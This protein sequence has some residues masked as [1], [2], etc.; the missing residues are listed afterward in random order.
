MLSAL[1]IRQFRNVSK[2]ASVAGPNSDR[3]VNIKWSDGKTGEFPLIWLRDTSPDPSTYTI[4]PAMT[5]RNL[6]MMEFDVEQKAKKIWIDSDEDSLKIEWESGIKS[7]FSSEWLQIRNPSDEEARK[8]RRKV[9]LFPEET[10]GKEEIER[11]LK[12]FSHEDFMKNDR[13]VHDFLQAVCID[14]IAVLKGAPKGVKG[15]VEDIGNRIGMIK[16]THFGKFRFHWFFLIF[17]S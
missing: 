11:K 9:Y 16:R 8:R 15:A 3:I 6:T 13:V 1:L 7:T 5:A 4:S 14:G 10:W 17:S 2:L 12:K